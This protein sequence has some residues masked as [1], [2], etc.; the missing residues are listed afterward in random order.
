MTY[1]YFIKSDID[2]HNYM[3]LV[4]GLKDRGW[5]SADKNDKHIDF[6][7]LFGVDKS[8]LSYHITS[9]LKNIVNEENKQVSNKWVLSKELSKRYPGLIPETKLLTKNYKLKKDGVYILKPVESR[10]GIGIYIIHNQQQLENKQK[11]YSNVN[12]LFNINKAKNEDKQLY[13]ALKIKYRK[14]N[15]VIISK[16][17]ENAMLFKKKRFH[18][19]MYYMITILDNKVNTY[20]FKFGKLMTAEKDYNKNKMTNKPYYDTHLGT[21]DDDYI[22]PNVFEKNGLNYYNQMINTLTKVTEVFKDTY[23][24]YSESKNCF[25]IL[26]TDFMITDEG[27]VLLLEINSSNTGYGSV[28]KKGYDFFSKMLFKTVLQIID[29]VFYNK[30]IEYECA[31]KL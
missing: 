6:I 21:T 31:D 27:K 24:C 12:R 11:I 4:D 30:N 5:R 8:Y 1:T 3:I 19:R 17:I 15:D 18:I 26:G 28:G 2:N 14:N 13:R 9:T 22:F 16:F 7:W 10:K 20:L 25:T 29:N 23:E